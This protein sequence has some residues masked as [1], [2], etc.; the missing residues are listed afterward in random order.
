MRRRTSGMLAQ[1]SVIVR[2]GDELVRVS[3]HQNKEEEWELDLLYEPLFAV[4]GGFPFEVMLPRLCRL[5]LVTT[6][7]IRTIPEDLKN[8]TSLS[9][10][11]GDL[12]GFS[13][14]HSQLQLNNKLI[15]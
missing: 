10:V 15:N 14:A 1:C 8:G 13:L 5:Q 2:R 9:L 7:G 3:P 11:N 4:P 12:E 6:R